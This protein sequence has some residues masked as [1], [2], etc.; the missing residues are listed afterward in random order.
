MTDLE[1]LEIKLRKNIRKFDEKYAASKSKLEL[2]LKIVTAREDAGLT[3]KQLADK[4]RT[5]QSVI[6]RIETGKQNLSVDML[7][8]IAEAVGKKEVYI[9][10]R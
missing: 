4:L 7:Y 2:A 5:T 6:S 3:Q 9:A 10:F 1:L 8:R